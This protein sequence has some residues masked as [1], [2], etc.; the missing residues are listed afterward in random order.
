VRG[1]AAAMMMQVLEGKLPAMVA[2]LECSD[3]DPRYARELRAAW[4]DLQTAGELWLAWNRATS[5]DGSTEVGLTEVASSSDVVEVQE[6]PEELSPK[7]AAELHDVTD[8]WIRQL[9]RDGAVD[10]RRIGRSWLVSRSSLAAFFE[11]RRRVA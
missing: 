4:E 1:F 8:S 2:Q 10:G 5:V 11:S 9:L 3:R 7:E 6:L